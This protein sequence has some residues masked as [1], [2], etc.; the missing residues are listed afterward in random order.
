MK[1]Y[2]G[3]LTVTV[4]LMVY[5]WL[6]GKDGDARVHGAPARAAGS[7]ES[8]LGILERA[9][10]VEPENVEVRAGLGRA[11]LEAGRHAEALEA[12]ERAISLDATRP[13]LH[14][15]RA[16]ALR[17]LG[18]HAEASEALDRVDELALSQGRRA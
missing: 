17:L 8:V 9:S 5:R 18:R 4:A 14:A 7:A 10:E 16:R 11:L 6:R 1:W 2:E 13:E 15:Q 12:I 3:L